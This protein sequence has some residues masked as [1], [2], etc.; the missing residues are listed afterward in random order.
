MEWT[1]PGSYALLAS[2]IAV[3]HWRAVGP[4]I[5]VALVCLDPDELELRAY[6]S[7]DHRRRLRSFRHRKRGFGTEHCRH[8]G[9]RRAFVL[10][11]SVTTACLNTGWLCR[12]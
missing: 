9:R 2:A 7:T 1:S 6:V 8:T 12:P 5:L 4:P 11:M 10:R 3:R